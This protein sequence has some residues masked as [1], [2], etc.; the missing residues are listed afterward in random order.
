MMHPRARMGGGGADRRRRGDPAGARS[1][2]RGGAAASARFDA[3]VFSK[4]AGYRHSGC[5]RSGTAAIARAARRQGFEVD[6]TE[7]AGAFTPRNLKRYDVV[8][9]LCTTGD[10]LDG[11]QQAA[12]RRYIGAGGGYAGIHSA[13]GTEYDWA[14]YGGLVGAYFRDHTGGA[15]EQFQTATIDVEDRRSAATNASPGAGRG[16]R[17]GTASA[18]TRATGARARCRSTS[19]P[20]TPAGTASRAARR[21]W[22]TI[23]SPGA[24]VMPA[25][26]RSTPRSAT[27]ARTG[28]S[29]ASA[30][31]CSAESRW[32]RA[33]PRSAAGSDPHAA[34]RSSS[35]APARGT[36]VAI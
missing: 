33:P 15:S 29:R 14:W 20:T 1:R 31:M 27:R 7:D 25:A 24:T 3:L 13:S 19:R 34:R 30:H 18:R 2:S 22:A 5:I 8:V 32:P 6:A 4:T 17:S 12:F 35:R 16:R 26:A 10:V 21:R 36:I 9:F 11:A 23:R 28:A